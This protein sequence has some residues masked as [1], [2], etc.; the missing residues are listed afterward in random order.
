MA[1]TGKA[2]A[3]MRR[4]GGGAGDLSASLQIC[5]LWEFS[6]RLFLPQDSECKG[7]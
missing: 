4:L 3:E 5:V 7:R 2:P 1:G 6:L